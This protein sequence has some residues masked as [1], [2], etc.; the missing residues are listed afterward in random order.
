M[1]GKLKHTSSILY[2]PA[3]QVETGY[4]VRWLRMMR[5]SLATGMSA[6]RRIFWVIQFALLSSWEQ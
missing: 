4:T 6:T 5:D 1:H 3:S 2:S